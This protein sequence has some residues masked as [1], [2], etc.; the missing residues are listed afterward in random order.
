MRRLG[1]IQHSAP[2]IGES[3]VSGLVNFTGTGTVTIN[4]G[5][6]VSSITDNG[7][8]DWTVNWIIPGSTD[9]YALS[10]LG[11]NDAAVAGGIAA[12]KI[13]TTPTSASVRITAEVT[14]AS[15]TLADLARVLVAQFTHGMD[16]KWPQN[17]Q[18]TSTWAVFDMTGALQASRNI[19]S[20]TDNGTGNW[21]VNFSVGYAATDSYVV[22]GTLK[23]NGAAMP[24]LSLKQNSS[25]AVNSVGLFGNS[26]TG[27]AKD[28]L[29]AYFM[30]WGTQ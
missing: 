10:I 13:S 8:G 22:G 28:G 18:K 25:L 5:F 4:Y 12:V 16:R 23:R 30:A 26:S 1:R 19:S 21:T 11:R 14:S 17:F 24:N 6:N 2:P 9:N 29:L 20:I 3:V 7:T 27:A 15:G